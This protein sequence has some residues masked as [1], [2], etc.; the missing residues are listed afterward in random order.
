MPPIGKRVKWLTVPS[1]WRS[2][3]TSEL[4]SQMN[5]IFDKDSFDCIL[6]FTHEL[7]HA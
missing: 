4:D 5:N 6:E 7:L 3:H 1:F 2:I